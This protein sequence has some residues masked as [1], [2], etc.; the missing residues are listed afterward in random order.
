[1]RIKVKIP[2]NNK[3]FPNDTYNILKG[4]EITH[5]ENFFY[6]FN[7]PNCIEERE[8]LKI[9]INEKIENYKWEKSF[10]ERFVLRQESYAKKLKEQGYIL[11]TLPALCNWRLIIG[12]GAAHPQETSMTLHHLYGIPYIPGSAIKGVTRHWVVFYKF[13]NNERDAEN[14]EDFKNIFGT[15]KAQGKVIF[16]DAYPSD[17]ITLKIDI[18]NPHYPDYYSKNSP[19][20]DWQK[21]NPIKFLTVER[22]KFK[23]VLLSKE[24]KLL[25]KAHSWLSNAL[26]NFGIGAK[27]SLGYGI[28]ESPAKSKFFRAG[29]GERAL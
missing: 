19:P 29:T 13:N 28:F 8:S 25:E 1:M 21:P 24:Q 14:D 9:R 20:A 22:T 16:M 11:K 7:T 17:E 23:F 15:Q 2:E 10:L 4:F 3:Y 26:T 12:L 27:T 18:M 5:N 6:L